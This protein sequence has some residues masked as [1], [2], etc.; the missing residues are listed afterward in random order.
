MVAN[1]GIYLFEP[2]VFTFI[3]SG[4][5]FDIGSQLFPALVAAGTPLYGI[6]L[7]FT[8]LEIGNVRSWWDAPVQLS[9]ESGM[10]STCRGKSC[11]PESSKGIAKEKGEIRI[12]GLSPEVRIIFELTQLHR[13][14]DIYE[15]I[16]TARASFV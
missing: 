9:P 6:A 5:E 16:E 2:E 3:P 14:F 11:T 13:I 10:V 15:N 7:P 1:T 8:W 12:A 4:A